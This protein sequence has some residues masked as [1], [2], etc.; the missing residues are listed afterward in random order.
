MELFHEDQKQ[1]LWL[2]NVGVKRWN[3]LLSH[4]SGHFSISTPHPPLCVPR[5]CAEA[6]VCGLWVWAAI[7]PSCSTTPSWRKGLDPDSLSSACTRQGSPSC[8]NQLVLKAK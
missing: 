3:F 6:A 4:V 7:I 1:G 5:L 2:V 8:S